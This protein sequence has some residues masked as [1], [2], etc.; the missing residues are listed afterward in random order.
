AAGVVVAGVPVAG[1][2]VAGVAVAGVAVAG[3]VV[4]GVAVAGVAVA[5]VAVAG[6][7]VAGVILRVAHF[8]SRSGVAFP[9]HPFDSSQ[10]LTSVASTPLPYKPSI[11]AGR[12]G[13]A[14][15][16]RAAGAMLRGMQT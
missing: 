9:R 14:R 16:A 10:P 13:F 6:V 11:N 3:V 5:G 4:A 12:D 2:A 7:P 8:A 15:A 1:V